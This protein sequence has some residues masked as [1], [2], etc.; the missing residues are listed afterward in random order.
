MEFA[1]WRGKLGRILPSALLRKVLASQQSGNLPLLASV[2]RVRSENEDAVRA[3]ADRLGIS[4][5]WDENSTSYVTNHE[6][7]R[8]LEAELQ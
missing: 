2:S 6:S 1:G 8:L 3:V 5:S 4:Y 7:W